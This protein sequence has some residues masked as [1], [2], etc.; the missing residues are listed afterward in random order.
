MALAS[1]H[2]VEKKILAGMF[3]HNLSD[4]FHSCQQGRDAAALTGISDRLS[5]HRL[6]ETEAEV[7]G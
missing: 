4:P 1:L 2:A 6:Q 5:K 3:P 7:G